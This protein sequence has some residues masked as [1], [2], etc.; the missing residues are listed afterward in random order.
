[1]ILN[2]EKR[3]KRKGFGL[4]FAILM[5]VGAIWFIP[6]AG[7]AMWPDLLSLGSREAVYFSS[8]NLLGISMILVLNL[9]MWAIYSVKWNFFERYRIGTRAWPWEEN[10]AAWR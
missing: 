8:M 10:P 1:M 2:E 7:R 3:Y 4:L 5:T 9:G 6:E